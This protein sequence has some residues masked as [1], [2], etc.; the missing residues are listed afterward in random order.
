MF[1]FAKEQ[2]IFDIDGVKIGGQ[3]GQFPTVLIGSV[4]YHGDKA[5]KDDRE[6]IFDREKVEKLLKNEEEM[7]ARTGNPRMIDI[8][9]AWP[10]ALAKYIDFVADKTGS[11]F[12]V[13]G[14][15]AGVRIEAIR[16]VREVGLT[17]RAIFNS[18]VP[19]AKP[20][21]ITAI[22]EAGLKSAVMLT[23]NSRKPTLEGRM[24][25]LRG[26]SEA[27]GLLDIARE[28]E[29]ENMLIDTAILDVPDPGVAAKTVYLVKREFGLPAGCGPHNALDIWRQ[30]KELNPKI[31]MTGNAVAHAASIFMGANFLLYG[32]ISGA[33]MIYPP[34]ALADA[35]V[36]Y[37]MRQEYGV[38]PLVKEHPLFKI[39]VTLSF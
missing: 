8:V 3:P 7:S 1:K 25:V 6:G 24:E 31:Y 16:H 39:F 29:I 18:I 32:P 22:K 38:K 20:E 15:T 11:P 12:L 34:C 2:K 19:E 17:D 21:E 14:A 33:S 27:K 4:F 13:D 5:V 26:T 37:C 10:K 23:Y 35:Y 30:R 36:A 28:A 9:G